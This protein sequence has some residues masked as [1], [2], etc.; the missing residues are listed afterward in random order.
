MKTIARTGELDDIARRLVEAVHYDGP[1]ADRCPVCW[2]SV[3]DNDTLAPG[4]PE[5]ILEHAHT[6]PVGAL[7]VLCDEQDKPTVRHTLAA[8]RVGHGED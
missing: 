8:E 2:V 5:L 6:C 4:E 3:R 1:W 7:M